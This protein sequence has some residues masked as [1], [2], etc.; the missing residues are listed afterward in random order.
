[1]FVRKLVFL[2]FC[3]FLCFYFFLKIHGTPKIFYSIDG[4]VD[5]L[6]AVN[7]LFN[8]IRL[9]YRVCGEVEHFLVFCHFLIF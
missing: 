7:S 3:H 5:S 2:I 6:V 1:M 8:T 9:V 4:L